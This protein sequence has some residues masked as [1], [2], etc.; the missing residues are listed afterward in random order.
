MPIS[1]WFDMMSQTVT[2]A[3]YGSRDEFG[4]MTFGAGVSYRHVIDYTGTEVLSHQTVYLGS[5]ALIGVRDQITLSTGDVASTGS[6]VINPTILAV[7]HIPD[8]S[9][10][11]HTTL[12]LK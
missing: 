7:N 6:G 11:H 4:D 2:I 1:R 5:K 10:L 8:Q 9:G 12:F 3:P